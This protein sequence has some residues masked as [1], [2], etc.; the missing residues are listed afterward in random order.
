M[1]HRCYCFPC[2]SWCQS[3][4]WEVVGVPWAAPT[5]YLLGIAS[6]HRVDQL[7]PVGQ[8]GGNHV[9]WA[10][11]RPDPLAPVAG[12]K[13]LTPPGPAVSEA[14]QT[15]LHCQ[16]APT[17]PGAQQARTSLQSRRKMSSCGSTRQRALD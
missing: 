4:A 1:L 7:D 15:L 10:V 3:Q 6:E 5:A 17:R 12:S 8:A 13:L 11:G 9:A 16:E 14:D 2:W